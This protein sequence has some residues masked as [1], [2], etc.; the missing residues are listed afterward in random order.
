MG[1]S[2]A[3]CWLSRALF[4]A[5][6]KFTNNSVVVGILIAPSA[7]L[8]GAAVG[9]LT[10]ATLPALLQQGYTPK[11]A[12]GAV[13]AAGTLGIIPPRRDVILLGGPHRATDHRNVHWRALSCGSSF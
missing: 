5:A 1:G 11:V 12:T 6:W 13:A 9:T 7:G 10:I 8:I 4:A 3:S 2:K